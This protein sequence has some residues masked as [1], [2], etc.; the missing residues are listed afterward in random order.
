MMS[1]QCH[2]EVFN[3]YILHL[4]LGLHYMLTNW[5]LNKNLKFFF[6][7]QDSINKAELGKKPFTLFV[8]LST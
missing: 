6:T 5:N 3:H 8:H 4:E 1:T 7:S 2:M